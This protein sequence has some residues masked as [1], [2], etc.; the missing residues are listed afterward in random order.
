MKH[1]LFAPRDTD[2]P[3]DWYTQ[4]DNMYKSQEPV[5]MMVD[6]TNYNSFDIKKIIKLKHIL[7]IYRPVTKMYLHETVIKLNN[8]AL[9]T[10]VKSCLVLFKP[11]KPVRFI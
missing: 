10:F 6:L 9:K 1:V 4:I 8:P 2:T 3:E 11:E 5:R 7:D